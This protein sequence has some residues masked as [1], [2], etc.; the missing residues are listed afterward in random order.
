MRS[1]LHLHLTAGV[2]PTIFRQL[3]ETFGSAE[4][5]LR[6]DRSALVSTKGV[7]SITADKIVSSRSQVDVDKELEL[8]S[9]AGVTLLSWDSSAYPVGLKNIYDPPAVLYVR[10]RLEPEDATAIA[11]VGTRR[12]SRYGLEQAER[13]GAALG[14]AGFT[15][16]SGLARGIDS[17]AHQGALKAGGRTIA[18]LGCGL[19]RIFPP[20]NADLYRAV[21]QN[22][23]VLSEFP[24][25][26]E[27]LAENFPRRNRIISGLSL[28][29]LVIEGP[30]R[31]GA[32]ITA[33]TAMEQGRDVFALPGRVDNAASRGTNQLIKDG[34]CL[35]ASLE[36][37]LDELG[38]IGEKM[39]AGT[40]QAD[41]PPSAPPLPGNL[42]ET[43]K[44]ILSAIV[45]E[46]MTV[47]ELCAA[48]EL[49]AGQVSA[50]LTM[51]QLKGLIRRIAGARFLRVKR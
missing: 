17:A 7:G 4:A 10:G 8:V 39:R 32:M 11:V 41:K 16:V 24:M 45:D 21:A 29:V 38:D 51:L 27:P 40:E 26:A 14:R 50:A 49:S 25:L 23:A 36:D 48:T 13:F 44:A 9:K 19:S 22:G 43:D 35:V 12:A 20:E 34:A 42:S 47:D 30:L 37:I 15:V 6:A 33:R 1:W 31:S 5:T 46:P 3:L 28:G 18:V 2:G